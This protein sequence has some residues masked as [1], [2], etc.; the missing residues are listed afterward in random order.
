[1]FNAC[2]HRLRSEANIS[3]PH[4]SRAGQPGA[5]ALYLGH[6]NQYGWLRIFLGR[7]TALAC[8][9]DDTQAQGRPQRCLIDGASHVVQ[10]LL[11]SRQAIGQCECTQTQR[12]TL[13][14]QI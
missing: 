11:H 4:R 5:I 12:Q 8:T 1:M 14:M 7:I 9:P 6:R 3:H 10:V 13:Q 2:E